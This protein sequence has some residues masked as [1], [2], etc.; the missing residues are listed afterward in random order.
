MATTQRRRKLT[1]EE[2][3]E[4]RQAQRELLDQAVRG[5][6]TSDGWTRWVRTRARFHR[7]SWRNTML[8][9]MQRPLAAN[10]G[11]T[12]GGGRRALSSARGVRRAR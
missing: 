5:L 11:L 7:Y 2:R 9:A 6:L 4:R 1:D 8:I 10:A 12:A 3:S